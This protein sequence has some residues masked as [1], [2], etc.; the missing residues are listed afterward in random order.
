[1]AAYLPASTKYE[2]ILDREKFEKEVVSRL[3]KIGLV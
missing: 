3:G 2:A 1:M